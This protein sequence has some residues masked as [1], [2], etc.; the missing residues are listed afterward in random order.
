[1][2]SSSEEEELQALLKIADV[3]DLLDA[4]TSAADVQ[5]S[6]P[7]PD[8]VAVALKKGGLSPDQTY[9]IGDTPY[10][11]S[12]AARAGVP[13]LA[14]RCGGWGDADLKDATAVYAAPADLLD[15]YN[16]SPLEG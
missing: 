14:V 13:T 2:A 4:T 11:I 12:S 9:M 5:N 15:Q 10:D 6:K 16:H 8:P 1:V 3:R 7:A